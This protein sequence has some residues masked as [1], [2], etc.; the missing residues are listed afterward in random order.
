MITARYT[1]SHNTTQ[2]EHTSEGDKAR[3]RVWGDKTSVQ[4]SRGHLKKER[5][6]EGEDREDV[7]EEER[8]RERL[9]I[10]LPVS[11]PLMWLAGRS[12]KDLKPMEV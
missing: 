3:L 10:H 1:S 4:P 8:E 6:R 11:L 2:R 7:E 12:D 9:T 5:E